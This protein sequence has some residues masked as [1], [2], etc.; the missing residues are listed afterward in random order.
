[1]VRVTRDGGGSERSK[2]F[3]VWLAAD[4]LKLAA[5]NAIACASELRKLR[6]QGKVQ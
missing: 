5:L 2:R 3:W 6:P 1:M 4:N